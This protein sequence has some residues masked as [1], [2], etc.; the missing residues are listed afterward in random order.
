MASSEAQA[1]NTRRLARSFTPSTPNHHPLLDPN[2]PAEDISLIPQDLKPR[3]TLKWELPNK[4]RTNLHIM[5]K[6]SNKADELL[7]EFHEKIPKIEE[8]LTEWV[9]MR[10]SSPTVEG[11][12]KLRA[13]ASDNAAVW[14]EGAFGQNNGSDDYV[15]NMVRNLDTPGR[16][17][18]I[19]LT[20]AVGEDD[21]DA[22]KAD[23]SYVHLPNAAELA[24]EMPQPLNV[25]KDGRRDS[26]PPNIRAT[27]WEDDGYLNP[28]V[29]SPENEFESDEDID[30]S[31]P[32]DDFWRHHEVPFGP[33]VV[34][35]DETD[36]VKSPCECDSPRSLPERD[37]VTPLDL[38]KGQ[39]PA[40]LMV[41]VAE[42]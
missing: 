36:Q 42:H 41:P 33:E 2:T 31:E 23:E 35:R 26:I 18:I 16:A 37:P 15:F 5:L 3:G 11:M 17:D 22:D 40:R 21:K 24:K 30:S 25:S 29:Y 27:P 9:E 12:E 6:L 19:Y 28:T 8:V 39:D 34:L 13:L 1:N 20:D 7:D 38:L 32:F 4:A 14:N 10:G